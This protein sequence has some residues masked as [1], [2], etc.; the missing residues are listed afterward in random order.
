VPRTPGAAARTRR[1][2][3]CFRNRMLQ[4]I[5][6]RLPRFV[7]IWCLFT[8]T[9][10][11]D[12]ADFHAVAAGSV[13][14]TDNKNGS[15]TDPEGAIFTDVRPGMLF[16]YNASR[17]I[18][19]LMTE[20]GMIYY[21]GNAAPNVTFRGDWKAFFLPGPRSEVS[22]GATGSF[23]QLNALQA[24]TPSNET[25][26][27]VQPE[28]KVNTLN[29]SATENASWVAT[30]FTRLSQRG[31]V[32]YTTTEDTDPM[33]AVMTQSFEYGGAIAIDHRRRHDNFALE[34]GASYVYMRKDD[35]FMVQMGD[36]L[37]KQINPRGVLVWQHDWN[38]KWST[39]L[40]AGVVYVNP[41]F[42][43]T[44]DTQAAPFPIFG[45]TAAYTDVWGRAQLVARRQVTPN[46][47]I[48]QNTVSDSISTTFAMPLQFLDRDG[49]KRAPRVV[50]IGTLGF[51]RTQL[52]DPLDA[53]LRGEFK[54]ARADA[55][56]AWQP[57]PGQTLG[58]RAEL[59]YQSGD[60]VAE[61][62]VPSFHRFTFYFTFALRWPEDVQVRVPRRANS[63]RADKSDLAP[64]G[65]EPVVIDPTE[66]LEEGGGGR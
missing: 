50:G 5:V 1:V 54:V 16:T 30:K 10:Y 31:F 62:V 53:A 51:D 56:V 34:L 39:Q 42:N 61:M 25:P 64:I 17:M 44:G 58:L 46:L 24:S 26:L 36:R 48:A 8:G 15:G 60:Q 43:L 41:I 13:A 29:G 19:E 12:N 28:G 38:R 21:L 65:S 9:A 57:R 45:A 37:D 3:L 63:V 49:R 23:G 32:R 35:P 33:V 66:L 47:F 11:A 20:V 14:T 4:S 55:G 59:T 52:I 27:L 22:L 40:D 18:H 2:K 6:R 7:A